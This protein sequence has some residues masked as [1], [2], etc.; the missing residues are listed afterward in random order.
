MNIIRKILNR[1][2]SEI[3]WAY[4][5]FMTCFVY[6]RRKSIGELRAAPQQEFCDLAVV[7]FNNAQVI[8]YQIRTLR[9]FFKMPFRYTVFDNST[10]NKISDEIRR[11]CSKYEVGFV[12][13]PRQE[14][15]PK[16]MGSYSHGIACNY[17]FNNY[18]KNG[19]C[20]YFGLLDHDIF[21]VEAFDISSVLEKQFFY[22]VKHRFY[23]WPGFFFMRMDYLLVHKVDF[24]PSLHLRG[25]TGACNGP[26]LFN[27]IKWKNFKLVN[28]DKRYFEGET[29][30]FEG[31]YSY[32]D[33]GWVHCWNASNYMNKKNILCKMCKI[34]NLIEDKLR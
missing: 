24:R 26:L 16:G 10:D 7:S 1:I 33:C 29:D 21:P 6:N 11:I 14:F 8:E 5:A 13:L 31:G 3:K 30:F 32:F 18:I 28:D 9:A 17:L 27:R 23:I 19:G 4:M 25:D 2:Q 22:G 15:L 34:F 12:R 20:K